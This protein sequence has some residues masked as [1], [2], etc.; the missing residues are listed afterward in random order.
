VAA[1]PFEIR[2]QAEEM[3]I[4]DGL[5]LEQISQE[6]GVS[7]QAIKQWSVKYGWKEKRIEY[8]ESIG[9]IKRDT[10][11]LRKRLVAKALESL[12]PRD[13]YSFARI[14]A[15]AGKEQGA[16]SREEGAWSGEEGAGRKIETAAEAVE[17]LQ[18]VIQT[19][20]N[21][22][23]SQPGAISLSNVKE[24]KQ[25]MELVEEMRAK[26]APEESKAKSLTAEAIREIREQLGL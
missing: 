23:L 11:L 9:Q 1:I 12:D 17:A 5:T 8:Q 19:K 20:I 14:E 2:D 25:A 15:I 10:Q 18:E 24:L 6:L 16:G 4:A 13:V 7:V 3:Y 26:A 22:M 21:V